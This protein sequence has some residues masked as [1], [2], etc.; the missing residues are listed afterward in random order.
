[1]KLSD[2]LTLLSPYTDTNNSRKVRIIKN[3]ERINYDKTTKD[4][5]VTKFEMTGDVFRPHI[6]IEVRDAI[7]VYKVCVAHNGGKLSRTL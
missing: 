2:V 3:G 6:R 4:L 7:A 5:I 1:M